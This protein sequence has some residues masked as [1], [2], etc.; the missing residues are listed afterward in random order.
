MDISAELFESITR[1]IRGDAHGEKRKDPRVGLSGKMTIVPHPPVA[2]GNPV[3]VTV[4]DL[5]AGG[6]GILHN[7]PLRE[8]QQFNLLLTYEKTGKS[9]MVLCTVRWSQSL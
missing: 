8:G 6:I 3:T 5:S 9:R 2:N 7:Q 4:R 1:T